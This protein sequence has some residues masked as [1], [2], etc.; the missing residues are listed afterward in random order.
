M[1]SGM[2]TVF[3]GLILWVILWYIL[4]VILGDYRVDL[5]LYGE[6]FCDWILGLSLISGLG[7]RWG[8]F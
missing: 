8:K 1:Y 3:L 4:R 5:G 2:Y 6:Y 7:E